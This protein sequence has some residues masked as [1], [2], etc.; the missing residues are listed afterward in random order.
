MLSSI[1]LFIHSPVDCFHFLAPMN[2]A[3]INIYLCVDICFQFSWIEIYR[4]G[5]AGSKR[6]FVYNFIRNCHTVFQSGWTIDLPTSSVSGLL[7]RI[8]PVVVII[9][10]FNDSCSSDYE[11]A[12]SHVWLYFPFAMVVG[13]IDVPIVYLY[14]LRI[15]FESSRI[16]KWV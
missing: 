14:T 15:L 6:K 13:T 16:N 7:P 12:S 11:S 1:P 3:A 5:I 2:G 8:L 10:I 9:C 4:I